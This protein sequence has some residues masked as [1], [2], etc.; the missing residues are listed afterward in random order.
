MGALLRIALVVLFAFVAASAFEAPALAQECPSTAFL[1]HGHLLF[2]GVKV[3]ASVSVT[4]RSALGEGVLDAPTG[5][6][7]CQR[8]R[9]NVKVMRVAEVDSSVGVAVEGRPGEIFVLGARCS[10]YEETERWDCLLEPLEYSGTAYTGV[11]YPADAGPPGAVPL[12]EPLGEAMLGGNTLTV[13]RISGV[14]PGVAVGVQGRPSEAFVAPRACPYERFDNRPAR[15]DLLRCLRSPVWLVFDPPGGRVGAEVVARA[16]RK[17]AP[18]AEGADVSLVRVRVVADVVPG[19]ISRSVRV[20]ALKGRL[21]TFALPDVEQGLY[22]AVVTCGRCAQAFGG[23]TVFPAG[24]LLVFEKEGGSGP[25][26]VGIGV[27]VVF[28]VLLVA[29]IVA[30]RKGWG[31]RRPAGG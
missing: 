20:A 7:P 28:F 30:W 19:D 15:D 29:S 8:K 6:D 13:H 16:D 5:D 2:A 17:L 22:E 3:P 24:S 4:L 26:L 23:R 12:A 21:V 9:E 27:G 14:D 1:Q 31:R 25:R 10:G 11:R 18:E